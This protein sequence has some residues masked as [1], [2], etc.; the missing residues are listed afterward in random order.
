MK[1]LN[2]A[3]LA[4]DTKKMTFDYPGQDGF[5]VTLTHLSKPEQVRIRED[6]MISKVDQE[7]GFPYTELDQDL[8]LRNFA[9]KAINGWKGLTGEILSQIMLIDESMLD[10]PKE[11]IDFSIDNAISMLRYSKA[12]DNWVT[13]QLGKIDNFRD[14]K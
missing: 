12:F 14:K 11:E 2:I 1:N 7:S 10:D 5:S 6:S 9:S 4:V 13:S 3:Q 8:Y